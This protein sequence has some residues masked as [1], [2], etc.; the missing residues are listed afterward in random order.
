MTKPSFGS[1]VALVTSGVENAL[2]TDTALFG[3]VTAELA[4]GPRTALIP[5]DVYSPG[6]EG[7]L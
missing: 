7:P 5:I 1:K 3:R 2:S 6:E 4:A